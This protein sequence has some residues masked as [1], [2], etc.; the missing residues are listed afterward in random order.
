MLEDEGAFEAQKKEQAKEYTMSI[1]AHLEKAFKKFDKNAKPILRVSIFDDRK[2]HKDIFMFAQIIEE[3]AMVNLV[4]APCDEKDSEEKVDG[5]SF[6]KDL[7]SLPF[8][9]MQVSVDED[10]KTKGFIYKQCVKLNK[11]IIQS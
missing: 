2:N 8:K 1:L 5:T 10:C 3:C 9:D 7:T 4:L 6:F 11:H